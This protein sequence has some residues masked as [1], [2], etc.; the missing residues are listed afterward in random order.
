VCK[1][2]PDFQFMRFEG[3]PIFSSRAFKDLWA[4]VYDCIFIMI[5]YDLGEN[6]VC[7]E[8]NGQRK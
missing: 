1:W 4:L 2:G 3:T 8:N 5:T 7:N 6:L